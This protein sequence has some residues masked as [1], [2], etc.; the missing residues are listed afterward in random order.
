MARG[1]TERLAWRLLA[2]LA[3]AAGPGEAIRL[4][5]RA[6]RDGVVRLTLHLPTA[7]AARDDDALFHATAATA[8]QALSAGMFGTGFALRL[9]AAEAHAVGGLLERKEGKLRLSLPQATATAETL[10]A[11]A[12][13]RG[14][15]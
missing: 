13:L 6:P 3:G 10:D 12:D 2:T 11:A 5:L 9:A 15:N 4:K 8:P 14:N 7:L 1:E